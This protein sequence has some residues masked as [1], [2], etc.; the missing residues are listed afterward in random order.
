MREWH[1]SFEMYDMHLYPGGAMRLHTLRCSLG[2]GL[3]WEGVRTYLREFAGKLVET[4]DFR[5]V[6]ERVS[7][8]SLG[9]FFDQWIHS[10]GY[11]ALEVEFDFDG[12]N[13][14]GTFNIKQSRAGAR[15]DGKGPD[16]KGSDKGNGGDR[17]F[18]FTL[19][20]AWSI[21]GE[22]TRRTVEIERERH[23]FVFEM[24]GDPEMVR[25]DPEFEVLHKLDFDPGSDKLEAQLVDAPDVIGRIQAGRELIKQAKPK[26]LSKIAGRW[27]SE[28]FW[29]VRLEWAKALGQLGN[30]GAIAA[31]IGAIE[32]ERDHRVLEGL[33]RA[34]G[35][36]RDPAL[37]DAVARRFGG[38]LPHRAA[39]AAWE[40]LGAQRE[41]APYKLIEA[42]AQRPSYNGFEQA[43]ALRAL[44]ATRDER[45]LD[46]LIARTK[47]IDTSDRAR[48]AAAYALGVLARRLDKRA[49]ERAIERLVELLRDHVPRVR[50]AAAHALEAARASEALGE[51]E[52]FRAG[53][54]HQEQVRVDRILA[55]LRKGEDPRLPAAEKEIEELREKLRKLED[56]V[57]KLTAKVA[58]EG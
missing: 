31:L 52:G 19:T 4:D 10:P 27:Q 38:G 15:P 34:C 37:A 28:P 41:R 22:L 55:N 17:P 20:L 48:P 9:K 25:V 57:E 35:E 45:A 13:H 5:R 8:R 3:F 24:D 6:M 18:A 50:M 12:K 46:Q 21:D 30:T 1:N 7:G 14:R 11:P 54:T 39:A 32:S 2:D 36:L 58:G 16:G 56:R 49:R 43:A 33:L 42:A 47:P 29:G 53:L 51:L 44:A 23:S 26:S 40:F